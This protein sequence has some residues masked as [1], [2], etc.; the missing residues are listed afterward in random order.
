M[1]VVCAGMGRA[2]LAGALA[3]GLPLALGACAATEAARPAAP[4]AAALDAPLV[5][6][7]TPSELVPDLDFAA[8]EAWQVDRDERRYLLAG[9]RVRV[10]PNGVVA[11]AGDRFPPGSVSALELPERLGGGYLFYLSDGNGTRLWRAPTW[12]APLEPLAALAAATDEVV[13]GFDRLYLR[14]QASGGALVAIEP[15]SGDL[16]PLGGLPLASGYGVMAFADGWRGVVDT[17]YAGPMASF[18]AGASWWPMRLGER[19]FG[20]GVL[21][22]DPVVHVSGGRYR[23]DAR[24]GLQFVADEPPS[25]APPVEADSGASGGARHPLGEH[26]LR[27]ALLDGWPDTGDS[28]V[29]LHEGSLYRV[30]LPSVDVLAVARRALPEAEAE[31]HAVRVGPGFGFVCAER[32]GPTSLYA[33]A[34]P[35]GVRPLVRFAEPR[36]V[37]PSGNG[38][39]VVRGPC[40]GADASPTVRTY[41]IVAPEGGVREVSVRGD[42]GVERVVALAD[43]RVV[44]LVPPRLGAP[45]LVNVIAGDAQT[46]AALTFPDKPK[47]ATLLAQRGMWLEGF[48]ERAPGVLAGWVEAGGPAIGVSVTLDGKVTLGTLRDRE[49]ELLVSGRFALAVNDNGTAEE[50]TDGGAT[51]EE[52]EL[53]ALPEGPGDAATRGCSPL[54]CALRGWLRLGWGKPGKEGD[55]AEVT[56]PDTQY[57]KPA[58][59]EALAWR[60]E[61]VGPATAGGYDAPTDPERS[62]TGW[63]RFMG[64]EPPKLGP[65]DVGVDRPSPSYEGV[66]SHIYVWGPKSADWTRAG[67]WQVRFEDRFAVDAGVRQS[68]TA[69]SPWADDLSASDGI[70]VARRGAYWKWGVHPD[71][72]G[73]A[74]LLSACRAANCGLYAVAEGRPVLTIRD[75]AGASEFVKPLDESAVRVGETWY[76]L[77][78]TQESIDLW[79]VDLGVARRFGRLPRV[80]A[81][82]YASSVVRLVRR[83]VGSEIGLLLSTDDDAN[84]QQRPPHWFVHPIDP[85]TG[86]LG[87]P[88]D[89]GR[90][91]FDGVAP[92]PCVPGEDG[93][94]V[95]LPPGYPSQVRLADGTA[96]F[97][98]VDYRLRLVPGGGC[99]DAMAARTG[100]SFD[101][102]APAGRKPPPQPS[103]ASTELPVPFAVTEQSAQRRWHLRCGPEA[104]SAPRARCPAG[105]PLCSDIEP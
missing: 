32:S 23:L 58:S 65:D 63:S 9:M 54:G 62:R 41:C 93:W 98:S 96:F 38:W 73:R 75:P 35:L 105:D 43:G 100:R 4:A 36:F 66:G 94:L 19:A 2:G 8:Q 10:R 26:P 92:P 80:P 34:P 46:S 31:C 1:N 82:R 14:S 81:R 72:S 85:Q 97:D 102:P 17:D 56:A 47:R 37:A 69:R 3:L 84:G 11:R 103:A 25:D 48:E 83:A 27:R 39:L 16:M 30:A 51:W 68:A 57:G 60:C 28:A 89:L 7:R 70:G 71:P 20:A 13:P 95:E 44:V 74:A 87:V 6:M 53:P 18:D 15:R 64:Q 49:G 99:V 67:S 33:F 91:D 5:T 59:L 21:G 104:A 22:G 101:E 29:V 90:S 24:G 88:V 78:D 86:A 40:V 76:F 42:V 77:A 55:L 45:G 12:V 61:V 52:L 50:S 79:R